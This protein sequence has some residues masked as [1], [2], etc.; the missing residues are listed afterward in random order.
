[1]KEIL[2][3]DQDFAKKI[4]KLQTEKKMKEE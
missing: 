1:M 2:E 3:E 4:K